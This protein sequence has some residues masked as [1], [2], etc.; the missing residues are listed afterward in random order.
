[1]ILPTPRRPVGFTLIEL[2]IS[3]LV[4]TMVVAAAVALLIGQQRLFQ[5]SSG[6]RALQDTARVA[7]G[8]LN[9]AIRMAGYG[10]D[11]GLTFDFGQRANVVMT[12]APLVAGVSVRDLG[13]QC[14]TDVACRDKVDGSDE[15][16]FY[17]RDPFFGHRVTGVTGTSAISIAG[18]LNIPLY[19]G[20]VLQL[21]C[22]SGAM[23]WA[24]VTVDQY[25]AISGGL[26]NVAVT[27]S[28]GGASA[29][30]FPKQNAA[31]ADG[32][33][34]DGTALAAKVDRFRYYV[35][36]RNAA[37]G[38][39][40][41]ET[42]GSRPFLMLDQGLTDEN[43]VASVKPVAPDIEDVQFSYLF[44]NAA[45][46]LVGE[47]AGAVIASGPTGIDLGAAGPGY[48]TSMTDA[49][50]LTHQAA[51][52]RGVRVFVVV[53][54]PTADLTVATAVVP[55]AAN[56]PALPGLAGYRRLL[57]STTVALPNLDSR[58]PF[59]PTYSSNGG[60]DNYNLG[61]G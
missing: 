3:L 44:P 16:V 48:G 55:A 60:V 17:A 8:E 26:G 59:I 9:D 42:A 15:I 27:L 23:L 30:D 39:V 36:T 32:C 45:P 11:P 38:V 40:A 52:I 22:T 29:L 4:S 2:M 35:E 14:A 6:D 21:M 37:G 10:V 43:G 47:T 31:I 1:M 13:Y 56:R 33:F 58:A 41:A 46:T 24:Y 50:R 49:S 61:G 53:R 20:Q 57:I 19:K 18:P 25:V 5:T 28:A 34:G 7:L 51:N 54:S 12:Q